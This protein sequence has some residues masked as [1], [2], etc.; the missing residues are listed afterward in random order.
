M[1]ILGLV[2]KR[3]GVVHVSSR[4]MAQSI[5]KN[6]VIIRQILGKLIKVG[7]AE[8]TT[9]SRG[10]AVIVKPDDKITLL[11]IYKAVEDEPIFGIHDS[12]GECPIAQYVDGYLGD[13]FDGAESK[14]ERDLKA[15]RLSDIADDL[16][17]KLLE[18]GAQPPP[19]HEPR[20]ETTT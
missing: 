20:H 3:D 18:G 17:D 10:G 14:F 9:G 4:W 8:S 15:V 1:C 12:N 5:D 11:D 13:L 6:E 7:L 2:R 19:Y 16:F